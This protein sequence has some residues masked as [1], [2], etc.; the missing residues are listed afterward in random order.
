LI[1]CSAYAPHLQQGAVTMKRIKVLASVSL[2]GL[3]S[4]GFAAGA[5]ASPH[6]HGQKYGDLAEVIS[7]TPI[8]E[9]V[10]TPRR[11]CYVEQ[12]ATYEERR[13]VR[14]VYDDRHDNRY[15]NRY[16][17]RGGIGPGTVLGAV[18]GGAIG[19]QFGNSSGGRDRGTA[20]GAIIGGVIGN[21]I[22]R[23]GHRYDGYQRASDVVE[24]ERVPVTRNVE[25]C[26]TVSDYRDEVVGYDVRYI[27]HGREYR[28]RTSYDPGRAM[29]VNVDVRPNH[30]DGPVPVYSRT[31]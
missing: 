14:R 6:K 23:N 21:D 9:R 5:N 22:E 30:R 13:Q 12:V 18:I 28:T 26:R 24:V 19:R 20:A 29:P 15:D 1:T 10:S 31:Y 7:S 17:N 25:R 8:Y 16:D 2:A 3:I 11:E 4:A 27:Y